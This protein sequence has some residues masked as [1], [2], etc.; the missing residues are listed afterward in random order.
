ME[1]NSGVYRVSLYRFQYLTEEEAPEGEK[2]HRYL[3]GCGMDGW[4]RLLYSIE[5]EGVLI[6][7][8][9]QYSI[10]LLQK[11]INDY[12]KNHFGDVTVEELGSKTV[13][14]HNRQE[15]LIRLCE[16]KVLPRII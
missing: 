15:F 10:E 8:K 2:P 14:Y 7:Q 5:S 3:G 9:D 1:L 6:L 4:N 13:T 16:G 11:F 12:L